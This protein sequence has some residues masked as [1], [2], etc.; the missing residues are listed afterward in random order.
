ML[1]VAVDNVAHLG[2]CLVVEIIDEI[3]SEVH[4]V[5]GCCRPVDDDPSKHAVSILR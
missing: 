1:K 4:V 3:S 2:C 5:I